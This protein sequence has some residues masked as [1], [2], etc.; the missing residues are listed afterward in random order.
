[1]VTQGICGKDGDQVF[2]AGG[3]SSAGGGEREVRRIPDGQRNNGPGDR[4][5]EQSRKS[6]LVQKLRHSGG[7]GLERS[8]SRAGPSEGG[9]GVNRDW[10][11]GI[12]THSKRAGCCRPAFSLT[13]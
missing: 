7:A 9:N 12:E 5:R 8:R 4:Y 3:F 11:L 6:S 2:A 1:M 13:R 10:C